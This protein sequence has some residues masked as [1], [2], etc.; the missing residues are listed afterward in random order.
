M[1]CN[2]LQGKFC[3]VAMFSKEQIFLM[4]PPSN[5]I[6]FL[7]LV[8]CA[9][10][11]NGLAAYSFCRGAA[12]FKKSAT[13]NAERETRNLVR[14]ISQSVNGL[15]LKVENS[16]L[17]VSSALEYQ[18]SRN[19]KIEPS[20]IRALI[21]RQRKLHGDTE[22][23]FVADA[24]GKLIFCE[25]KVR[26]R[27]V[28]VAGSDYFE[29]LKSHP[30]KPFVFAVSALGQ[31]PGVPAVLAV[32][33]YR[34]SDGSFAGVVAAPMAG[35]F[36]KKA[37]TGFKVGQDALLSIRT[38][39]NALLASYPQGARAPDA[40]SDSYLKFWRSRE[41]SATYMDLTEQHVHRLYSVSR[42][43]EFPLIVKAGFAEAAYLKDWR[44][45]LKFRMFSLLIIVVFSFVAVSAIAYMWLRQSR[46]LASLNST[47][48]RLHAL[49]G[50]GGVALC[51]VDFLSGR[52]E[53]SPEQ[54]LLF[55][56]GDD[57]PQTKEGWLALVYPDD[58]LPLE[59]AVKRS[60]YL[61]ASRFEYEYRIVRPCDGQVRWIQVS[62]AND[63][64]ATGEPWRFLGAIKDISSLRESQRRAAHLVHHDELTGLP[65]RSLL[66]DRMRQSLAQKRRDDALLGVCLIDIDGFKEVNDKFGRSVGDKAL[67]EIAMRISQSLRAGDTVARL[68]GDEFV[69]LLGGF[70]QEED[71]LEVLRRILDVLGNQYRLGESNLALTASA[72]V[73]VFPRDDADGAEALIRHAN[74]ALFEAKR[75]GKNR[76]HVFDPEA[77]KRIV[78][79]RN[80]Y[81]RIAEALE[82]GEFRLHYQP[83]VDLH[84]DAV[85]AVEALIRWQH[86]E[87]GLLSPAQFLPFVEN[88]DLTIPM[89]EW[90]MREAL[91]QKRLWD[92]AGLSLSVCVNISPRHL[93]QADFSRRLY[94]ILQEFPEQSPEELDLEILETTLLDDLSEVSRSIKEC[95]SF[96]VKFSLDDFGT[97]FSSLSYF[98]RLPAH[99]V[100]IDQSFVKGILTSADD[101]SLVNSVVSMAQAMQRKVVAEGVETIEHGLPLIRFGCDYAQGYGIA[102]PMPG[103]NILAWTE[104]WRRPAQW[105]VTEG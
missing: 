69:V 54:K 91:R 46:Y 13:E 95:S 7:W 63:Y 96:G 70:S 97:G 102:R 4:K 100:K 11:I 61:A 101:L 89:G 21:E 103:E 29:K 33:R 30:D 53:M 43:S 18:L 24:T 36:F 59:R 27:V 64:L 17:L 44:S 84:S 93:Q 31:N 23:W 19:G 42:L 73:T 50:I 40:F 38:S 65:N 6:F 58:L 67:T 62:G 87:E 57:Y 8:A 66:V 80:R 9:L 1:H 37:L 105:L 2:T 47:N 35:A 71:L 25:G 98:R 55:G 22:P 49:L 92:G 68:G 104:A 12:D 28:D 90:V 88:T 51:S 60:L 16:L 41:K 5:R 83:I 26:P 75:L 82:N 94:S 74:Q 39:G 52:W 78:E 45:V 81:Q 20:E 86:P 14:A 34:N 99:V 3:S 72:G 56:V 48:E 10:L 32:R 77:D 79:Q 15:M 76:I 85:V